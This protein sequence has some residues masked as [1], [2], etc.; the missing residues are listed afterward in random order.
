[1]L[2]LD[3]DYLR[4]RSKICEALGLMQ[5]NNPC[6]GCSTDYHEITSAGVNCLISG[7]IESSREFAKKSLE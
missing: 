3:N 4:L 5:N 7:Q 2:P 1:M 6:K